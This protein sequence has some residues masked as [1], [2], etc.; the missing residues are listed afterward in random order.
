MLSDSSFPIGGYLVDPSSPIPVPGKPIP[1]SGTKICGCQGDGM[2]GMLGQHCCCYNS[3]KDDISCTSDP[4]T[5][6][7]QC[8]GDPAKDCKKQ[9][10]GSGWPF[11]AH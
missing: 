8:C 3:T 7:S 2:C 5:S 6:P 1:P 10:P 9:Q 11:S 4:V